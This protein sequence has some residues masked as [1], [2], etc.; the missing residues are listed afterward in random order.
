MAEPGFSTHCQRDGLKGVDIINSLFQ[1]F[2][3]EMHVGRNENAS[4]RECMMFPAPGAPTQKYIENPNAPPLIENPSHSPSQ[5]DDPITSPEAEPSSS[6]LK[7]M[8]E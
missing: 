5:I 2:E 4:K 3:M 7:D 8:L 6:E 1:H